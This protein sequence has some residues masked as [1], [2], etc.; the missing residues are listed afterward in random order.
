M[1]TTCPICGR[2]RIASDKTQCPQCDADLTCFKVL[3]SLPNEPDQL[4]EPARGMTGSKNQTILFAAIVLFLGLTTVLSVFQVHRLKGLES[5]MSDLDASF[6]NAMIKVNTRLE[7]LAHSQSNTSEGLDARPQAA[8]ET[9]D[10]GEASSG[11]ETTSVKCP[12]LKMATEAPVTKRATGQGL[13]EKSVSEKEDPTE[14]PGFLTYHANVKDTLWDISKKYYG[15]GDYYPVL[16]EHNSQLGIYDIG[17]ATQVRILKNVSLVKEIYK[18]ITEKNGNRTYWYYTVSQGDT[19]SSVANKFYRTK[20]MA[21]QILDLNPDI[22]LEPGER[23]K[24]M[25]E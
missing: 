21:G 19:L 8:N 24:I 25:M 16:L 5:R 4:M 14:K 18:K 10:K 1:M 17:D 20:D 22:A 3:D 15:S 13:A 23:I 12:R 6:V 7:R 2:E 9:K 11:L